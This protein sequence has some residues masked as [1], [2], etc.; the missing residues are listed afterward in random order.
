[1]VIVISVTDGVSTARLEPFSITVSSKKT[2]PN[3]LSGE[4]QDCFGH[5][6][7]EIL[8][9]PRTEHDVQAVAAGLQWLNDYLKAKEI[10][11][12]FAF[13]PVDN[14]ELATIFLACGYRKTG[15][16]AKGVL[17][18]DKRSDAVLWTRK[19]ADPSGGSEPTMADDEDDDEDEDEEEEE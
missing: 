8:R 16:L 17:C 19:L 12:A 4:F 9:V 15:L 7:I 6:L 5:S 11:S 18:G 13:A 2:K 1:M 14:L 10:V 3:F